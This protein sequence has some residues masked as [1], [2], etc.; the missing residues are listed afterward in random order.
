[1]LRTRANPASSTCFFFFFFPQRVLR[2]PQG[3]GQKPVKWHP[4]ALSILPP[5]SVVPLG[6]GQARE[7][8][9]PGR[10]PSLPLS[11]REIASQRWLSPPLLLGH[12]HFS[13]RVERKWLWGP[14]RAPTAGL[15]L[16]SG[17]TLDKFLKP[18]SSKSQ[19]SSSSKRDHGVALRIM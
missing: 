12:R 15:P 19:F 8:R 5:R 7:R 6:W 13:R 2:S 18:S 3:L 17:V 1:M 9:R 10:E 4:A 11:W 16:S 14:T